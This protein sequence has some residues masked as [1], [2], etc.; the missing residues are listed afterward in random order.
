MLGGIDHWSNLVEVC[1]GVVLIQSSVKS[2]TGTW[3]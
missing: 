1:Q 3:E 2:C